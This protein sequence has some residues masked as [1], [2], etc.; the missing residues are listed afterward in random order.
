[1]PHARKKQLGIRTT[2]EALKFFLHPRKVV[3]N[4][5]P[6]ELAHERLEGLLV[7]RRESKKVN[8]K[9]KVCIVLRHNDFE[10][11][12]LHCAQRYVKVLTE[13]NEADFFSGECVEATV[14]AEEENRSDEAQEVPVIC[15]SDLAENIARLRMEGYDVDDDNEPA[16]ENVPEPQ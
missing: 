5:Y 1:M 8:N 11:E 6:N 13:G 14:I 12:E 3:S 16:P 9:E 10:N 15:N 7:L 2:C 4:K